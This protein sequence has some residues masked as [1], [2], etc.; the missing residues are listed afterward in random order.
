MARRGYG[1]SPEWEQDEGL[2][3]NEP[4]WTAHVWGL[5]RVYEHPE[6]PQIY[7]QRKR[8]LDGIKRYRTESYLYLFPIAA[9]MNY[10]KLRGLQSFPVLQVRSQN[11]SH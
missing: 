1:L 3:S 11:G 7:P 6:N 8:V 4:E 5:C 9:V 2:T 10:H